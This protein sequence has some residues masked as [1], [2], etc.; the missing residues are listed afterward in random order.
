MKITDTGT[1]PLKTAERE[2]MNIWIYIAVMAIVT[3]LIRMLPMT[4]LRK[5]IKN[6]TLR[7]FLAYVPYVTLTV[8]TFPA[9]LDAT[10]SI[11]SALAGFATALI[12][13]YFK[14]SMILV[15]LVSCAVVFITELI[16][17]H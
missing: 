11:Y 16:L 7:S 4:I 15:A 17:I 3:Y 8:M 13:S 12:M 14:K 9:I 6:K 10:R 1:R 2:N 5:E